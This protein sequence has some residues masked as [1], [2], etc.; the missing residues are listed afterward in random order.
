MPTI[1]DERL[2][3]WSAVGE[4]MA[5]GDGA[6]ATLRIDVLAANFQDVKKAWEE[7]N[8]FKGKVSRDYEKRVVEVGEGAKGKNPIQ[9]Y[10]ELG[11]GIGKLEWWRTRELYFKMY[12]ILTNHNLLPRWGVAPGF[13]LGRKKV[14]PPEE[15]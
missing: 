4:A 6:S 14:P 11:D 12:R 7:Y 10:G 1:E 9:Q 8:D 2:K 15:E 13:D 5:A 3:L